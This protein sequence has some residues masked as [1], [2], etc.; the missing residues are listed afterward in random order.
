M[1]HT[2]D[3]SGMGTSHGMDAVGGSRNGILS[4]KETTSSCTMLFAFVRMH[5]AETMLA[6]LVSAV[7]WLMIYDLQ[8]TPKL[9]GCQR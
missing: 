9:D 7:L 6:L 3:V 2:R 5:D 1:G 8:G 4:F